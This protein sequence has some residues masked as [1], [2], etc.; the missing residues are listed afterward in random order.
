MSSIKRRKVV[1]QELPQAK[2]CSPQPESPRSGERPPPE[3]S[4][5]EDICAPPPHWRDVYS[6]IEKMRK[7]RNAPVDKIGCAKLADEDADPK[8]YRW[9]GRLG[10]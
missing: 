1:K 4:D 5:I 7:A 3:T 2:K 6:A 8:A 10:G 9:Q